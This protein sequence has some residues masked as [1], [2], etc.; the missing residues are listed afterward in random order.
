M[1]ELLSKYNDYMRLVGCRTKY[2]LEN[3]DEIEFEYHEKNFAHLI[4]LHKLTDIQI[5]QFW[6]DRN[7]KSVKLKDILKKIRNQTFTDE[8]VRKSVKF[9]KIKDRYE[10]FSYDN[11][12]TLNYTDAIVN[13]DATKINS[14]LKS[15]YILFEEKQG[16]S[17]NHMGVALDTS[18]ARRYVETFFHETT[19]KYM[20]GQK[21][22][23]VKS[24]QLLD[25]DGKIVVE[26]KFE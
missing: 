22:V 20:Q 6:L 23:K 11:L 19:N 4:G 14:S 3:G 17:Y 13:F 10:S 21:I 15:D 12:S 1:N 16:T 18:L 2:I 24:F 7:N 5:V 8:M 26:D 9:S 25:K